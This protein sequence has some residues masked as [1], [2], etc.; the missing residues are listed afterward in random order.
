MRKKSL[1]FNVSCLLFTVYCFPLGAFS[2]DAKDF[3][4]AGMKFKEQKQF[5]SAIVNL[6]QAILLKEKFEEAYIQRADC[7][8][9]FYNYLEAAN[10]YQKL[11]TI[12]PKNEE[13]LKSA[14]RLYLKANEPKSA[15][16][17]LEAYHKN[18][19][20]DETII[21]ELIESKNAIGSYADALN[22]CKKFEKVFASNPVF[23]FGKFQAKKGAEPT[24]N[25]YPELLAGY[26]CMLTS[27][28]YIKNPARYHN[29]LLSYSEALTELKKYNEAVFLLR[30]ITKNEVNNSKYF[31]NRSKIY[32]E[33]Q[34]FDS[35]MYEMQGAFTLSKSNA[36]Y[37]IQRAKIFE[38]LGKWKEACNDYEV[39]YENKSECE[40][41][42]GVFKCRKRENNVFN[43]VDLIKKGIELKCAEEN[44][45]LYL[46][47][48]DS[49]KAAYK[50]ENNKPVIAIIQPLSANHQIAISDSIGNI[51][52][53]GYIQDESKIKQLFI[54]DLPVAMKN[55]FEFEIAIVAN[56]GD[57]LRITAID[58]WNNATSTPFYFTASFPD[59]VQV[60]L[61]DPILK[62]NLLLV[63]KSTAASVYITGKINYPKEKIKKILVNNEEALFEGGERTKFETAADFAGTDS[64]TVKLISTFGAV[65]EFIYPIKRAVK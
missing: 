59:S 41:V 8:T 64:L 65:K 53:K 22:Y 32:F 51:L 24:S 63:P 19:E 20:S 36:Q 54:N 34:L 38:A 39:A 10:D 30:T 29:Y 55:N 44:Y 46:K 18:R 17:Y 12:S 3:F 15:A 23:M 28:A 11:S 26:N 1:L 48:I 35:A 2:Q 9:K 6:S 52:L 56:G 14:G 16:I 60:T 13:Y 40:S 61:T 42:Y 27:E 49:I 62:N 33:Q 7:Y 37:F 57:S 5:D 43:S 31:Y 50:E 58:I 25:Y 47:E 4:E 45:A 21:P